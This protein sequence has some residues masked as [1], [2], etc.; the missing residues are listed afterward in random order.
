M[1]FLLLALG[2]VP[3]TDIGVDG[4]GFEANAK[5]FD[6]DGDSYTSLATGGTDCDDTDV[7]ISPGATEVCDSVDNDCDLDIDDDDTSRVGRRYGP[8]LDGDGW[9]QDGA[10]QT[11]CS[12]DPIQEILDIA[13]GDS[14]VTG[15]DWIVIPV[16]QYSS[17]GAFTNADCDDDNDDVYPMATETCN[18]IDDDCEGGIDEALTTYT[19]YADSDVDTY[20]NA[21]VSTSSCSAPSGYVSDST[22]CNDASASVHPGASETCNS[23]DDDCDGSIDEG[24]TTTYYADADGDTYG[25]LLV[26]AAACSAPSG[27]VSHDSDCDDTDAAI[28]P[29]AVEVC[30][31]VDN[32]CDFVVDD[33]V[34]STFY[35]D[36]DGDTYGSTASGAATGCSAPAG[37]VASST[38]C[39]D[40]DAAISPGATEVCD[41]VDNDCDSSTDE[42][43]LTTW[44]R[45]GDSDGYGGSTSFASCTAPASFVAT[46][47]DC[48]DT[49]GAVHPGATE[50]AG[51]SLDDDCDGTIDNT[52]CVSTIEII[53]DM[54]DADY[55]SAVVSSD[56]SMTGDWWDN[57][58]GISLVTGV[59]TTEYSLGGYYREYDSAFSLCFTAGVTVVLSGEFATGG[60]LCE[61]SGAGA[62]VF[63]ESDGVSLTISETTAGSGC[64][65]T[66]SE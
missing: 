50:V 62:L 5:G 23:V 51:N 2:C 45:D 61:P 15:D 16:E 54:G 66:I 55:I 44:Y 46:S 17:T 20:G 32:D 24:V 10:H 56:S 19:W 25:N 53:N 38:D 30:D 11:A 6:G 40:S 52:T 29:L 3:L 41:S 12:T 47:T 65:Y 7:A 35:V 8:D 60:M 33:G 39:N 57:T 26:T 49:N 42:G 63:A 22:D 27:Y 28:N 58:T 34:M 36:S 48:L 31:L 21:S 43:V 14:S 64:V 13:D 37:Y 18:G 4:N 59:T 9:A 1:T